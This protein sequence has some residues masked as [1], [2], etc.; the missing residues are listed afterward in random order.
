MSRQS[1]RRCGP[2][3]WLGGVF[4]GSSRIALIICAIERAR[5]PTS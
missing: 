3:G 4:E 2:I 1:K 5:V